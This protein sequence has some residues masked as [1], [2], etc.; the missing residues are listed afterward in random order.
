VMTETMKTYGSRLVRAVS[1]PV[2]NAGTDTT[3]T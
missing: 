2:L 1:G 3:S